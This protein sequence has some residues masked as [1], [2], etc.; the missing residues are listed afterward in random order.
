VVSDL[1][2]AWRN[3]LGFTQRQAGTAVLYDMDA[4]EGTYASAEF[5]RSRFDRVVIVTPR[6]R[7]AEDVPLVNRLGILRRFAHQASNP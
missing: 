1:R 4:T 2:A 5:L 6:D 3:S 7:I